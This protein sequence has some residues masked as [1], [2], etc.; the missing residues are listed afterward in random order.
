MKTISIRQLHDKTGEWVRRASQLGE[1]YVSE[2]GRTIAKIIPQA[3]AHSVPYF[4]H[5][6]LSRHFRTIMEK[7][8]GGRDSTQIISEDRDRRL[9]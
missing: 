2:R 7:L 6:K 4:A 5:R 1:I 8:K 9:G 3:P